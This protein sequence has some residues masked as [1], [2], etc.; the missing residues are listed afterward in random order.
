[1]DMSESIQDV[2]S[3]SKKNVVRFF[4]EARKTS[5]KYHQSL[6]KL[7]QDYV[8]AW[9]SVISYTIS[10]EQEYATNVGFSTKVPDSTL[11]IIHD[12]T[13]LSIQAYLQQN[14]SIFDTVE[15]T[16]KAFTKFNETTKTFA[17]LNKE[18]MEYLMSVYEQKLLT[19]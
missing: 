15:T 6:V 13:E 11:Q 7:Q 17:S 5:P 14:K 18:I 1:M 16:K 2:F 12:M 10:L 9:K 8:D 3:I 4:N 19:K